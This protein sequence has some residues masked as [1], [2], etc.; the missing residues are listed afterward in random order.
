MYT[1]L[2]AKVQQISHNSVAHVPTHMH[3]WN[4]G[5][6]FALCT[7][8]ACKHMYTHHMLCAHTPF[9]GASQPRFLLS[10]R[11]FLLLKFPAHRGGRS[12]LPGSYFL[13]T[14]EIFGL[15]HNI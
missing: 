11:L 2:C 13:N 1:V 9:Q 5:V 10:P 8:H 12:M 14:V 3:T 7:T 6:G 4:A 15:Y